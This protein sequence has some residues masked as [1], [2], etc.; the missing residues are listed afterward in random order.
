M[1]ERIWLIH[2]ENCVT[3]CHIGS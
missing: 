1:D 2:L 3:D